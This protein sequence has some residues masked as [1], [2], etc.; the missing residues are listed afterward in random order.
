MDINGIEMKYVIQCKDVTSGMVGD[1]LFDELHYQ[2]T[3]EFKAISPVF[4]DLSQFF[5]WQ[6]EQES[7]KL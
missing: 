5:A 7:K 6:K 1:F 3:G 4:P 2:E